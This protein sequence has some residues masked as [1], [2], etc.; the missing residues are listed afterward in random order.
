MLVD[1]GL[2]GQGILSRFAAAGLSPE[3]LQA[4]VISHE[5]RDHT[6]GVGVLARRL[7]LPV[8]VTQ[9]THQALNGCLNGGEEVVYFNSGEPFRIGDLTL[10]PFSV[11]HDAADPVGFTIHYGSR[12]VALATDLGYVTHLV[13][14]RLRGADLILLESNYDPDLLQ[15][16]PYP[17]PLKKRVMSR[18]GHLSNKDA[19]ALLKELVHPQLEHVILGHLSKTN[20]Y[21]ELVE[22]ETQAALASVRSCSTSFT[23]VPQGEIGPVF[24]LG[25]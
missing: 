24:S 15:G 22:A 3:R 17:W 21:R 23:V 7:K 10:A 6:L 5:H 19:A 8:Y 1:A 9:R 2:S 14:E 18:Q 12:K 11:P 20:N 16:G 25:E 13:R 4:L